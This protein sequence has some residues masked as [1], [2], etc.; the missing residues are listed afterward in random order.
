MG[1][2][3]GSIVHDFRSPMTAAR[4]YASILA[5]SRLGP[6]ER[7]QYAR[8]LLEECDRLGDMTEDLLELTR[9]GSARLSR[10]WVRVSDYAAT[11]RRTLEACFSGSGVALEVRLDYDGP[12]FIDASKLTRA[13]LNVA[14]NARQAMPGGGVFVF[15]TA[16]R[17]ADACRVAM[18]TPR[19]IGLGTPLGWPAVG[20]GAAKRRPR[21]PV[22]ISSCP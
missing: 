7:K 10:S 19:E 16:A 17:D 8:L 21:H 9:S 4:G 15:T 1:R 18:T 14:V 2:M 22:V 11:L 5:G 20:E 3:I 13:A 6:D 12:L